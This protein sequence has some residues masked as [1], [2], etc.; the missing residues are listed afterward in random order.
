[1]GPE[2]KTHNDGVGTVAFDYNNGVMDFDYGNVV[3]DMDK[4]VH[5][6]KA[7]K[8]GAIRAP[9]PVYVG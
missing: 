4:G 7:N 8:D 6:G 3:V 2:T 5:V 1:M 9:R